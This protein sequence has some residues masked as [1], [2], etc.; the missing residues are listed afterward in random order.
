MSVCGD[1]RWFLAPTPQEIAAWACH[2]LNRGGRERAGAC[3]PMFLKEDDPR[4]TGVPHASDPACSIN[5]E[6]RAPGTPKQAQLL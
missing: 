3:W 6:T 4:R 2:P 5:F 1:C